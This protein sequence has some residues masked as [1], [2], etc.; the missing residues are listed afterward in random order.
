MS[1]FRFVL[2]IALVALTARS[3]QHSPQE[4]SAQPQCRPLLA[5]LH[6]D[7]QR[8]S[9][10]PSLMIAMKTPFGWVRRSC[11][12]SFPNARSGNGLPTNQ[13][14]SRQSSL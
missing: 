5:R 13:G 1:A 12:P 7:R 8:N 14:T 2:L 4:L 9:Y 3:Q 6:V 11:R 10:R